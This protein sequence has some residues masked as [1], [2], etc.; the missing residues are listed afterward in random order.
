MN[1]LAHCLLGYPERGLIAGG[2]MGDFVKGRIPT[3]LP[4]ELARGVRLHRHLDSTSN[5]MPEMRQSYVHFGTELRRPAP[6]L[7]DLIADHV[8]A[9]QWDRYGVGDLTQFTTT[10][11]K[12]ID[13]YPLPQNARP[14]YDRM[15]ATDLLAQYAERDVIERAMFYILKRL[16][17][18]R[19]EK[20][21]H[22]VVEMR[23]DNFCQDFHQYFPLLR[24]VAQTFIAEEH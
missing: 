21:L 17:F 2:F 16:R 24:E 23:F 7:L 6:V 10:C 20:H 12:A 3:S 1:F 13:H 15:K 5:R 18:D 4:S 11:Y 14:F 22:Q 9:I 19:F 8:L